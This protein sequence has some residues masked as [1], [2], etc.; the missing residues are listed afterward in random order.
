MNS[1]ASNCAQCVPFD[2]SVLSLFAKSLSL[3]QIAPK[4]AEV[5]I[6]KSS[7]LCYTSIKSQPNTTRMGGCGKQTRENLAARL[8]PPLASAK[9]VFSCPFSAGID[10]DFDQG[11]VFYT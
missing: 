8:L 7:K 5:P 4:M 11:L 2:T 10:S 6:A 1:S 3:L 9:W